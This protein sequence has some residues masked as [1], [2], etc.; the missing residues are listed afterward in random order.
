MIAIL[1]NQFIFAFLLRPRFHIHPVFGSSI[2]VHK[3][4]TIDY[5]DVHGRDNEDD[6]DK[7]DDGLLNTKKVLKRNPARKEDTSQKPT[8]SP[9]GIPMPGHYEPVR[10]ICVLMRSRSFFILGNFP[11]WKISRN[12]K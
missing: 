4:Q 7:N 2:A 6:N 12:E 5:D 10:S 8:K 9:Y 11:L 3:C 1:K